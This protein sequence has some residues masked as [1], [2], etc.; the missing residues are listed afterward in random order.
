MI[1]CLD[2]K[3]VREKIPSYDE[4]LQRA[5][6]VKARVRADSEAAK[7]KALAEEEEAKAEAEPD[8]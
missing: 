5:D 8:E 1:A 4:D 2:L 7:A 6:A 3:F